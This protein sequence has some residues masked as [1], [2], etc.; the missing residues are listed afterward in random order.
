MYNN[1]RTKN[2]LFAILATG[3]ITFFAAGP[4]YDAFAD[5][6]HTC[7]GLNHCYSRAMA[8]WCVLFCLSHGERE[9]SGLKGSNTLPSTL[10]TTSGDNHW[11]ANPFWVASTTAAD[12]VEVG[13]IKG[14][15]ICGN[16]STAEYYYVAVKNNVVQSEGCI[17]SSSGTTAYELSDTN[18]DTVWSLKIAGTER[19]TSDQDWNKNKLMAGGEYTANNITHDEKVT[20]LKFYDTA[21]NDWDY[22]YTE[23]GGQYEIDWCTEPTSFDYGD[24]PSC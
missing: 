15:G 18:K 8:K 4:V 7:S 12:W 20:L 1:K 13:W 21:W 3:T 11:V 10:P 23:S 2:L 19:T 22:A 6:G 9:E 5:T 16:H 24:N 14:D 17:N